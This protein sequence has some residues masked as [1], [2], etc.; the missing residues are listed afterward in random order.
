ME[1]AVCRVGVVPSLARFNGLAKSFSEVKGIEEDRL[2]GV[3]A[4]GVFRY[5][6]FTGCLSAFLPHQF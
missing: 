3:E 2:G 5:G 6:L 4:E 1:L